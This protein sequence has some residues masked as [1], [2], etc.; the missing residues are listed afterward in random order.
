MDQNK[1]SRSA[2]NLYRLTPTARRLL[3]ATTRGL[4]ECVPNFS[5]GRDQETIEAIK[6][7]I[8]AIPTV[9]ILHQTSDQDHNRTV[10]TFIGPPQAVTDAAFQAIK[11]AAEHIDIT[12]HQGVHPFMGVTDVC[13]LIP[14]K[15]ISAK[16]CLPYADQLAKRVGTELQIPVFLYEQSA[17]R[18]ETINLAHIRHGGYRTLPPDYVP[19]SNSHAGSIAIGVR[20]LLIAFNVNLNT[21]DLKIAKKIAKSI[22]EKDGGLAKVKAIGLYLATTDTAQISMN[23]TDYRITPPHTVYQAIEKLAQQLGTSIKESEL[24]GLIPQPALRKGDVEYLKLKD[25][26]A[27]RILDNHY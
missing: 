26:S 4:I 20:D 3:T 9:K 10:F 16:E 13:P 22:R 6:Q 7:S 8:A 23:L 19:P 27:E 15:N 1:D 21:N 18:P 2:R 14:L 12:K 25:F 17:T 5:V 24:I 11:T